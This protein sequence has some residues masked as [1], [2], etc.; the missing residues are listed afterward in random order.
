[1]QQLPCARQVLFASVVG[2]EPVVTDAVKAP[3]QHMQQEA[4]HEL[5]SKHLGNTR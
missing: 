1:M 3:R 5:F 4:A 2:D